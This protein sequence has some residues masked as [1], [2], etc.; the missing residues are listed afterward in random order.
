MLWWDEFPA[1]AT[2][3][4]A[5]EVER[6]GTM[7]LGPALQPWSGVLT[8]WFWA[9]LLACSLLV[10]RGARAEDAVGILRVT[11][12]VPDAQVHIDNEPVGN[13]PVT[14]YL[15][16]GS[17]L[18]RVAADGYDPFVRKVTV[19]AN[20]SQSLQAD[21]LPGGG[22]VEFTVKPGGAHVFIDEQDM[23]MA[24]IRLSTVPPGEHRYKVVK[25]GYEPAEGS[26]TLVKGGNPLVSLVLESSS[27][28][29]SILSTPPGAAVYLDG[30]LRGNTPLQLKDVPPGEHLV[31]LYLEGYT[32]VSR[33]VDTTDGS[34]GEV[35]TTL[36]A[37]GATVEV[38]TGAPD[39]QVSVDAIPIGQGKTVSVVLA[40]GEHT[41][42]VSAPGQAPAELLL[43]V[44]ISGELSYQALLSPSG[45]T[46]EVMEPIY[47]RWAFWAIAGGATA[48]AAA[49]A[50][51]LAIVL[52]PE[53]P[54]TGDV[55]V[56]L[57]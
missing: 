50:T 10:A 56:T 16:P 9:A 5:H 2:K 51:T 32:L 41:L 11:A 39:G 6:K 19:A 57:P 21:L 34:R 44:P 53:P 26:F 55:V 23:G 28:R 30:E 4:R 3:S 8:R 13:T 12:S 1:R 31:A 24:P 29:F 49:T 18:V 46:I 52:A 17:Y 22:S 47:K 20:V 43:D 38:H 37:N 36:N 14:R 7:K 15:P 48:G 33:K 35:D 54:P 27:G 40:R 42:T 25:D 45:S